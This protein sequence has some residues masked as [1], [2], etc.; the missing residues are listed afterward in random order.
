MYRHDTDNPAYFTFKWRY[1]YGIITHLIG[2][3][4]MVVQRTTLDVIAIEDDCALH[5][6]HAM[7]L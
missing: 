6:N 4:R 7:T 5:D 1:T 3:I 2:R